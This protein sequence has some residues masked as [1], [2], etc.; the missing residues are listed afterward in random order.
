ML[1][2]LAAFAVTAAVCFGLSMLF[3]RSGRNR[4]RIITG[5]GPRSLIFG[6]LTPGLAGIMPRTGKTQ[7]K[8][9]TFLRHAGHYHRSALQEFNALRCVLLLG[10]TFLILALMV[11]TTQPGDSGMLLWLIVGGIGA[12]LLYSLPRLILE[13]MA[14]NR[15]QRIE[16][17]LPDALDMITMC[18]SG[19]LPLQMSMQRVSEEIEPIHRDLAFELK[20]I[21]RQMEAGSLE[22]SLKQFA[23]RVDTP[24][25]Q[26]LAA[27]IGQ[28]EHQGA[29]AALAFQDFADNVR[30][31][32]RQRADEQGNKTALKLL[33]PLVFCLAPPVYM[34]LLMPAAIEMSQFV[35]RETQPGGALSADPETVGQVLEGNDLFGANEST[36]DLMD[37]ISSERTQRALE[38][39]RQRQRN[40]N[41]PPPGL[42]VYGNRRTRTDPTAY[43]GIKPRATERLDRYLLAPCPVMPDFVTGSWTTR[44]G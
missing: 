21:G 20:V 26:S 29:S 9:A 36:S 44:M 11:A 42:N 39:Q 7:E 23:A 28:S 37:E 3:I 25:V 34:M 17:S 15:Q 14:K 38:R 10:W 40:Q 43:A 8:L 24:D 41:T 22:N 2:P 27:I 30:L 33:F 19:G 32:R 1:I 4:D 5:S 18:M 13:T 12:M 16:E 31:T 35:K 6:P